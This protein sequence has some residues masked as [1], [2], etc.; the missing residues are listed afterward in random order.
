M[1]WSGFVWVVA[2]CALADSGTAVVPLPG[3]LAMDS[4]PDIRLQ[5]Q[6]AVGRGPRPCW[7]TGSCA[8][9]RPIPAW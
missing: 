8:R 2:L 4:A 9:P 7:I 5:L 1:I 3:R 6:G